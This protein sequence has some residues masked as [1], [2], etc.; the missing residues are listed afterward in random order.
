MIYIGPLRVDE[1][2]AA[3]TRNVLRLEG[4][5][6]AIA[7]LR[8]S[9]ETKIDAIRMLVITADLS[10]GEA[11]QVVHHSPI[12]QNCRENDDAFHDSLVSAAQALQASDDD[13]VD[14][15]A[16]EVVTSR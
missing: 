8:R 16:L 7:L 9:G 6:G 15:S 11:K 1:A 4:L 5:E 13:L 10:L 12:W 3:R 14:S 2:L